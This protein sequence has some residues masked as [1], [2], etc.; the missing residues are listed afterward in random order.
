MRR[1]SIFALSF[2]DFDGSIV[3]YRAA[4]TWQPK[5]YIGVGAGYDNF[6]IDV[7]VEKEP[8]HRLD[9]LDLFGTAGLLQHSVLTASGGPFCD[10]QSSRS[11]R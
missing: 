10:W 5:K 11:R 4:V 2:D 3:N 6:T 9:G 8:L 1:P 7:D